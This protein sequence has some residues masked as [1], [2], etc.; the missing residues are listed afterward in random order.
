MKRIIT[1]CMA[2]ALIVSLFSVTCF[3]VD[4]GVIISEK[5]ES[6]GVVFSPNIVHSY[7]KTIV[8]T[9]NSY[10]SVPSTYPYSE[11]NNEYGAWFSGTLYLQSVVKYGSQWK[12]TFYGTLVG[13]I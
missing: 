1:C 3:A 8:V 2:L 13:Y 4:N 6:L 7:N 11:Y 5:Q 9:Y 12:A 10:S